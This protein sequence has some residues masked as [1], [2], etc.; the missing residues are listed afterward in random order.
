[1]CHTIIL[2]AVKPERKYS[3]CSALLLFR[4]SLPHVTV[5]RQKKHGGRRKQFEWQATPVK[6][7]F[8]ALVHSLH[9]ICWEHEQQENRIHLTPFHSVSPYVTTDRTVGAKT[10]LSSDVRLK[11]CSF[12]SCHGFKILN[13]TE[14]LSAWLTEIISQLRE[15]RLCYVSSINLIDFSQTVAAGDVPFICCLVDFSVCDVFHFLL[16]EYST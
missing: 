2:N 16:L 3:F 11:I 5:F 1:M 4:F 6:R 15:T 7:V 8:N 13:V 10:T 9:I 12:C 14:C